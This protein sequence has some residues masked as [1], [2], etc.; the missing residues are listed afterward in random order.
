MAAVEPPCRNGQVERVERDGEDVEDHTPLLGPRLGD[1]LRQGRTSQ[2]VNPGRAHR[3]QRRGEGVVQSRVHREVAVEPR[4]LEGSPRLEAGRR[5]QERAP[6]REPRPRLDQHTEACRVDEG[7]AGEI[8]DESLRLAPRLVEERLANGVRVVQVELADQRDHDRAVAFLDP[9]HRCPLQPFH[10][11]LGHWASRSRSPWGIQPSPA[12]A[13]QTVCIAL[14]PG[15]MT[16]VEIPYS[17][18]A[19]LPSLVV[20]DITNDVRHEVERSDLERML[21]RLVPSQTEER[22][23]LLTFLLGPR[24]EQVPFAAGE[25]CLGDWQRILLFGFDGEHSL[26]WSLTLLG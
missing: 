16:S 8:D 22:E 4:D 10:V 14:A 23:R 25:L 17:I 1:F 24:G 6:V 13:A 20:L 5:E 21:E 18:A 15:R 19:A 26:E 11:A 2:L 12:A 3:L 7:D 9:G